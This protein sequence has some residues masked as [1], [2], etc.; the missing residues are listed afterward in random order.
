MTLDKSSLAESMTLDPFSFH[1]H[2]ASVI[3][4][5]GGELPN[6]DPSYAFHSP[7]VRL[8]P[9]RARFKIRLTNLQAK[10][11]TLVLRVHLLPDAEGSVASMV[12]S[13]R[14]QLNRLVMIGGEIEVTFEAFRNAT[15]ALMGLVAGET[16]ASA[17]A[18]TI[19]ASHPYNEALDLAS[20]RG[21]NSATKFG[22]R[23][24][25]GSA[26]LVSLMPP[27]LAYPASQAATP[28]QFK[29]KE[30]ADWR[31]RLSLTLSDRLE[32]WSLVYLAQALTAYGMAESGVKGL[33][34]GPVDPAFLNWAA[35][36]GCALTQV[37]T[38]EFTTLPANVERRRLVNFWDMPRDL[39]DFDFICSCRL[40]ERLE[41]P[42]EAAAIIDA[43]FGTMRPLA[44]AIHVVGTGSR[45][46]GFK[47][48]DL[49]R[50]ALS[51]LS[52]GHDV[53]QLRPT[54]FREP[55]DLEP[56]AFGLIARRAEQ[57]F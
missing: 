37:D 34:L 29:E 28:E 18:L 20:I 36:L 45:A 11:G 48:V 14:V 4:G 43:T 52:K 16:D 51:L 57:I 1:G 26:I 10:Q 19:T 42:G 54:M 44:L 33:V 12:T 17:T 5:I 23:N 15:Y 41:G 50:L 22:I 46:P 53:S 30:F 40:G 39:I 27:K 47:R 9:G 21:D 38:V 32:S 24:F 7:Y 49:E 25:R 31:A 55:L 56:G 13:T 6:A 8:A 2:T 3:K 35:G